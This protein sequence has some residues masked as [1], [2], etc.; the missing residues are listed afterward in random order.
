MREERRYLLAW[1]LEGMGWQKLY[2]FIAG[3]WYGRPYLGASMAAG[4]STRVSRYTANFLSTRVVSAW[5]FFWQLCLGERSYS[6]LGSVCATHS[7]TWVGSW[8]LSWSADVACNGPSG[9][10]W[11]TRAST[12]PGRSSLNSNLGPSCFLVPILLFRGSCF[13]HCGKFWINEE[14][15][16]LCL[17]DNFFFF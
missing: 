4:G 13:Q 7:Q 12:I 6:V 8:H 2:K 5:Q 10:N 14:L 1:K 11:L 15:F 9:L 3:D 16:G 17:W